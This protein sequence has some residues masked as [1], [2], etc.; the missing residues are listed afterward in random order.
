[1][2][3][4]KHLAAATSLVACMAIVGSINILPNGFVYDDLI[5]VGDQCL[6]GW[7]NL[8]RI[9]S[10]NIWGLQGGES[11]YYRPAAFFV[12]FLFGKSFGQTPTAWHTFS[13]LLHA[14]ASA[15]VYLLA[16]RICGPLQDE[17]ADGRTALIAGC[18]FAVHPVHAEA[19]AWASAWGE[20]SMTV[21]CVAAI[22][23]Y[24]LDDRV[25][26]LWSAAVYFAA[27]L[28][29]ET[30]IIVPLI[31]VAY[32]RLYRGQL[33][34]RRYLPYL[35][36]AT[37]YMVIRGMALGAV[38]P[39]AA[40]KLSLPTM[41]VL[42]KTYFSYLVA[43]V[44][45]NVFHVIPAVK[46]YADARLP[47]ALLAVC[48]YAAALGYTYRQNKGWCLSLLIIGVPLLPALYTP[49]L[50]GSNLAERYL[51]LPSVG[52]V[53][54]LAGII[55]KAGRVGGSLAVALVVVWCILTTQ[56]NAIWRDDVTLWADSVAKA[57]E[58]RPI[59]LNNLGAA[60]ASNGDTIRAIGYFS[61]AVRIAPSYG[62]AH[63]NLALAYESRGK[64][65]HAIAEYT[66]ALRHGPSDAIAHNNLGIL[67]IAKGEGEGGAAHI[68]QAYALKSCDRDIMRNYAIVTG[69]TTP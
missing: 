19:V 14:I 65:E 21:L 15:S 64:T 23:I 61:E 11:H 58:R 66:A 48:A 2:T 59:P 69:R 3:D 31:L 30:G 12:G 51:Y 57:S 44:G 9:F 55:R 37:V 7:E 35:I 17:V 63:R 41:L 47:G 5:W 27:L 4:K 32:D 49:A 1:M 38:A 34:W 8:L 50:G 43:P 52:F 33:H 24:T 54:L 56:R 46:S 28:F 10:T 53:V 67:L 22:Y 20:I 16:L 25:A 62:D 39:A 36:A 6:S 42:L 60:Y 18:L 26:P 40:G 29:K 68:R 13:L 45:L